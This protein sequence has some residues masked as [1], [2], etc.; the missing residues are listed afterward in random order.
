MIFLAEDRP[1]TMPRVFAD[2]SISLDGFVAG[3]NA[4]LEKPLGE[5]GDRLHE[6]AVK[7]RSWRAPHG[8]EGGEVNADD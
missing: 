2:I 8:L 5:G 3:P 4:T 1:M 7:L 6:W